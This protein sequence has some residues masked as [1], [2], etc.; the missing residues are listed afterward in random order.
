MLQLPVAERNI[1]IAV[2]AILLLSSI[3]TI[4]QFFRTSDKYRAMIIPLIAL[5]ISLQSVILIFRAVD[6]KSIPLTGLFE[7]MIVLTIAFGF[8]FLF[9]SVTIRHVWFTS[10]MVWFISILALLSV[11]V[12]SPASKIDLLVETPWV[13]WHSLSMILSGTAILFSASMAALFLLARRNLK[14]KKIGRV[15]GKIPNIQKLEVLNVIGIKSAFA[16]LSFGLISGIGL[17]VVKSAEISI[18]FNEWITDSKIILVLV[19]WV[20]LA[21]VLVLRHFLLRARGLAIITLVSCF[22]II[23]SIIGSS[24]FCGSEHD[25]SKSQPEKVTAGGLE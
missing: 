25:F 24:I 19:G 17:A 9:L 5:A 15:I 18:S 13:V 14:H 12:A 21:V 20:L 10:V 1:L 7:S 2:V 4:I 23:F 11:F 22:L 16:F 6:I 8:T 3:L